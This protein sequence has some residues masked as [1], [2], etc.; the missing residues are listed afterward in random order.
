MAAKL[1][2]DRMYGGCAVSG[3]PTA[4]VYGNFFVSYLIVNHGWSTPTYGSASQH[5]LSFRG[6]LG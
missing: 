5:G 6:V 3:V 4:L 2:S 1:V